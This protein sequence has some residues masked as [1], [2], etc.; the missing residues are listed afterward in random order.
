MLKIEQQFKE[1]LPTI[2]DKIDY[3]VNWN[4]YIDADGNVAVEGQG[5]TSLEGAPEIV[6]GDFNCYQNNLTSLKG[7]PKKVGWDFDCSDNKL[8]AL[9]GA[10]KEVGGS[11]YCHNNKVKFTK[12]NVRKVCKVANEIVVE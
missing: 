9:E 12:E 6:G 5:L 8:T 4:D 11:F 7:G 1:I 2:V 3:K 10:P